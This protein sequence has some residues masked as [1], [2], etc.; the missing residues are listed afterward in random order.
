MSFGEAG[1]RKIVVVLKVNGTG[2]AVQEID[3]PCFQPLATVRGDWNRIAERIAE[4]KKDAASVWLEIIYEGDEVIG[5]LQ[6]RLREL[7][8]GTSLEILRSK[9]LRLV[10][11]TLS[12]LAAEETLDDLTVDEVFARCLAAHEVSADQHIELVGVFREAVLA[13]HEEDP[14]GD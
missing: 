1:Q 9:N 12:R 7:I 2:V 4:L 14:R 13:L 3:V 5:D 11:R 6:E 10:D 8:D